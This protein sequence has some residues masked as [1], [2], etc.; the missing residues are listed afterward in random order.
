MKRDGILICPKCKKPLARSG[1]SL[2]CERRHTYDIS[3]HGYVNLINT[4]SQKE[5]GD[6]KEM[7][8][9]RTA[10]LDSG[11]YENFRQALCLAAGKGEVLVDAGCGEGYYTC[12]LSK[13][14]NTVLGFDLSKASV[15][16][17]CRRAKTRR[18][19]DKVFFGVGSVFKIP[20]IDECADC[21]VSIFA[22]CATEEFIRILKPN[23]R[24]IIGCAGKHHLNEMKEV[25]YENTR[26][27]T[28]RLDLPTCLTEISRQNVQYTV[29]LTRQEDIHSLYQMTPYCHKTSREATE[30]LLLL[31]SLS[32]LLDFEIRVYEKQR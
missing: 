10:F 27:N 11:Y 19:Q 14:Y 26:E 30:R 16:Y 29:T 15:D 18:L 8:R 13:G 4:S 7:S 21:V 23:G 31:Q 20:V 3:K 5:S 32:T 6:S 12:E 24:L 1:G 17:A 25:L 2:V 9:A 22:P 28:D